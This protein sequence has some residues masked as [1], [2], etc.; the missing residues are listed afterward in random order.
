MAKSGYKVNITNEVRPTA[1]SISNEC[2]SLSLVKGG[3]NVEYDLHELEHYHCNVNTD[4]VNN[5][6]S[7]IQNFAAKLHNEVKN[8]MSI[9][10]AE[11]YFLCL[12]RYIK[13]CDSKNLEPF[14]KKGYLAFCGA[15]GELW[16]QVAIG[17]EPHKYLFMYAD[18]AEVGLLEKTA[19]ITKR[20]LKKS[21]EIA[22]F[23]MFEWDR[24]TPNFSNVSNNSAI[25]YSEN[26]L[27][28]ALKRLQLFFFAAAAQLIAHAKENPGLP[29]PTNLNVL[30]DTLDSGE[31]FY[32]K[33]NETADNGR[34]DICHLSPFN[35]CMA[36]GYY[37]FAHYSAFN[38]G[39]IKDL[40]R[41][42]EFV[43][44][45]KAGKTTRHTTLR[46]WKGRSNSI[47]QAL[48]TDCDDYSVL[49][50][51]TD[52][53]PGALY[54]E[55]DK[56][57]GAAFIE[58]LAELS[59]AYSPHPNGHLLY[60]L[61]RTGDVV[62]LQ[63]KSL[64]H[65][66]ELLGL[67]SDDRYGT[68]NRII[69]AFYAVRDFSVIPE[70]SQLKGDLGEMYVTK[71]NASCKVNYRTIALSLYAQAAFQCF[72]EANL[73]WAILP[74]EI[75]DRDDDGMIT[76]GFR[77]TNTTYQHSF[78]AP[79]QYR[80]FFKDVAKWAES[81]NPSVQRFNE[82]LEIKAKRGGY[83]RAPT[84][85]P[86]LFPLGKEHET[87]QD[88]PIN[89]FTKN[90]I[91]RLGIGSGQYFLS[92]LSSRFRVTISD[93]EH[94]S[95]DGGYNAKI[96]LQHSLE[97]HL[98]R[99]KNGNPGENMRITAQAIEVF[100]HILRGVNEDEAKELVRASW[101][102]PILD[103]DK[104]VALRKPSN[105]NGVLCDGKPELDSSA[106][107]YLLSLK[108]AGK[109]GLTDDGLYINCYQFDLCTECKNAKLV[110]DVHSVYKMLSFMEAL[111]DAVDLYPASA[112]RLE[113]IAD[114]FENLINSNLPR[115]TID[116]AEKR[117][118]SEGRYPLFEDVH[119]V[120][121]PY[122]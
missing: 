68:V 84:R 67:L 116:A 39:P 88:Y 16:R 74:L 122:L 45:K 27:N 3:K 98:T 40:R 115:A 47:V 32:I 18:G 33:F 44:N 56:R 34:G 8:G 20:Q 62:P 7:P 29:P 4:I 90:A 77:Y 58:L 113:G 86:Y 91:S 85:S 46:G 38:D 30:L 25:P 69:E 13:Y 92:L 28:F 66:S 6:I 9:N 17:A 51:A 70:C 104:Y 12:R 71:A 81:R 10:T 101:Q 95:I 108:Q 89:I 61:N 105:P 14:S 80:K 48:L 110:D 117:L 93:R 50:E 112:E 64:G 11:N 83:G 21:L 76:I 5:R 31:P 24:N 94:T 97:Q 15:N 63:D 42:V 52:N 19:S 37:I 23:P 43:T 22:G 75:S 60:N 107:E 72:T 73:K 36:A 120:V 82:D 57:N 35:Q 87:H 65:L 119:S 41:P 103:H 2:Y 49:P 100:E 1:T 54:A 118:L 96:L 114:S 79:E 99:Y 26:E 121:T 59:T 106:R 78:K 53:E 111:L 109:L 102:I 55:V